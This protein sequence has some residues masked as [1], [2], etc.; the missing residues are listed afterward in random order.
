MKECDKKEAAFQEE[1]KLAISVAQKNDKTSSVS[2]EFRMSESLGLEG[3]QSKRLVT[4]QYFFQLLFNSWLKQEIIYPRVDLDKSFVMCKT[5]MKSGKTPQKYS[6]GSM[7]NL[8][9]V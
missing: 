8:L 1:A 7:C 3:I 2:T 5:G 6:V 4:A 9:V